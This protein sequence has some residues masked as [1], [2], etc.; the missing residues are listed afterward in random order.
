MATTISELVDALDGVRVQGQEARKLGDN[1]LVVAGEVENL[2]DD[3]ETAASDLADLVDS[4]EALDEGEDIEEELAAIRKIAGQL[5][6]K[7]EKAEQLRSD[8]DSLD[9][10]AKEIADELSDDVE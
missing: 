4:I 8:L 5:K 9:T 7:S 6:A 10:A 3:L 1:L 2:R